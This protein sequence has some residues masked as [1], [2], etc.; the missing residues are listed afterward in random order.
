MRAPTSHA[1]KMGQSHRNLAVDNL[2]LVGRTKIP[3][4][5]S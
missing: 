1:P 3:L 2:S 4:V 5:H